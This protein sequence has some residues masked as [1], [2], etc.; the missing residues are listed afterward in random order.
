MSRTGGKRKA[1]EKAFQA[2]YGLSFSPAADEAS[3]REAF[4]ASPSNSPAS[5]EPSG[6]AWRL[7]KG[8]WSN[9]K[10]LDANIERFSRNWRLERMG[11]IELIL[12][13]MALFETLS[14]ATPPKVAINEALDL[15]AEFGAESA[16]NFMNG[17]LDAAAK[18]GAVL[19]CASKPDEGSGEA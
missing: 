2:L 16:K 9:E 15:A 11:R 1:R 14:G 6:F 12:L 5:G 19:E 4:M 17:V 18:S 13:R 10:T 3:L 7:V 8:V